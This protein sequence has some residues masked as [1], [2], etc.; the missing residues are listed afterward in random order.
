MTYDQARLR[1]W[2]P[3]AYAPDEVRRAAIL[4]L[5]TFDV[6]QEDYDQACNLF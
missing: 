3:K 4:I 5:A 6:T 1:I 2:N